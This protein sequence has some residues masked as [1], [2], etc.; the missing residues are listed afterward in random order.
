MQIKELKKKYDEY[1]QTLIEEIKSEKSSET[2]LNYLDFCS[3]FHRYSFNNK[4][5]IWMSMPKATNVAGFHS[6]KK[7]GR[8][9]K[10]GE[11]GIPIFAPMRVKQKVEPTDNEGVTEED[12]NAH[13]DQDRLFFKVVY[14]WDVSQTEGEPLPEAPD[15]M[16]VSGSA[17]N[18]FP[19]IEK[20]ILSEGISLEYVND[21]G[22]AYGVSRGGKIVILSS[23]TDTQKFCVLAHELAHEYLHKKAERIEY[24]KKLK[25]TEAE[26][27]AYIVCRHFGLNPKSSTYLAAY[28]TEDI[29]IQG[30][31]G[32]ITSTASRI[33]RGIEN[34]ADIRK[35][36]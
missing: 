25:E 27:T 1:L 7:L 17:K 10:K 23:L 19:L 29:D 2:L 24:S 9:V 35:A 4:I 21:L 12:E 32:R 31:F 18:V 36:A 15:I 5:L 33:L 28:Q 3:K 13:Q 6:W 26:A 34:A 30:S 8:S 11:K 16:G 22:D 14:V 20:H